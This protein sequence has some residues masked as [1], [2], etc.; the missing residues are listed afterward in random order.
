MHVDGFRFDLAAGARRA[1]TAASTARG[2]FFDA[3]AQDPVLS[4]VKLIAEPWDLGPD[5]YQVGGF[6]PGWARVERPL[7]RHACAATGAA[8]RP[9]C[10]SFAQRLCGSADIY[11]PP[12]PP[13]R[14][15]RQLR[16]RARRLHAARPGQL[17]RQAQRGQ[18]R[19]QPRRREPQ[20]QLEL[21]RR[22]PDRRPRD[23]ARCA[24]ARSATCSRRC[25]CRRA[26][27][28]CCGGDEIGRTQGGNNNAYCQDNELSWFDW[29]DDAATS[30]LLALHR[31]A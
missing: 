23:P 27:R 13:A 11:E 1:A 7:P 30:A 24:S 14:R 22:R 25:C 6:P 8:R 3:I 26:C 28:C 2:A 16:H 21:R 9:A 29:S 5:G 17:Q 18:R 20:P 15:Q 31:S 4:R 19:G 12:R 10:R